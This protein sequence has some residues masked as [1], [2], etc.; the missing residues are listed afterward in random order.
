M[1]ISLHADALAHGVAHGARIFTLSDAASDAASAAL[2]ERHDR[3]DILSGI[4]LNGADDVV[5]D[6]CWTWRDLK[7]PLGHGRWPN[8]YWR[9]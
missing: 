3:L 4:D 1:F 6:V 2:A 8:R 9:V 5:T 7:P